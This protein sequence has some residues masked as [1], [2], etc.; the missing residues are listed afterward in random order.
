M[1]L[2]T[3]FALL[4]S[5]CARTSSPQRNFFVLLKTTRMSAIFSHSH[6][7]FLGK[8]ST[9]GRSLWRAVLIAIVLVT[10][11]SFRH[12]QL[13]LRDSMNYGVGFGP[14]SAGHRSMIVHST[15][16]HRFESQFIFMRHVLCAVK[17]IYVMI[18]IINFFSDRFHCA[19]LSP[20]WQFD[21][22]ATDVASFEIVSIECRKRWLADARGICA[23]LGYFRSVP[24][25]SSFRICIAHRFITSDT[26]SVLD[27]RICEH[28][29]WPLNCLLGN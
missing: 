4:H 25:C 6:I 21:R 3:S 17:L 11:R 8:T 24:K 23:A 9:Q 19:S 26:C 10:D 27:L 16:C 7:L 28:A 5:K 18:D 12:M 20:F 14:L 29:C 13:L 2:C 1:H 15:L 22:S